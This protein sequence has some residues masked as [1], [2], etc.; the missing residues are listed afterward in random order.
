M[1]GEERLTPAELKTL[2][3]FEELDDDQLAWLAERGRVVEYPVGAVIHAEG[4]IATCFLVL[5]SGT[6]SM[7]RRVQGGTELE[8]FRTDYRG[9]YTGAFGAWIVE[10]GEP[11]NYA[12]TS[13]A[14][15]DCRFLELPA[16]DMAWAVKTWFPMA[17]HLMVGAA[18]QG[19]EASEMIERHE[20]LVAL[21]AVTAGLT[22]ELNNPVAA[23]GRAAATL[24]E[25]LNGW[26][27]EL[28]TLADGGVD[29]HQLSV[30][31][32]LVAKAV[33]G[34]SAAPHLSP[35]EASDRED[36]LGEWLE[37]HGV[38]DS[39]DVAPAL[40]AAGLDVEAVQ[41]L[42]DVLGP[43][44][45]PSG[46]ASLVYAL[47]SD[48]LVEEIGEATGRISGLLASAKQYTQ[49][50]R[51]PLQTFEV[52]EG[53]EATLTMLGHE[54]G[55]VD[56]VRDYDLSLPRIAAYPAELNQVWTNLIE[57][58]V[59]AMDGRGI[60]TVR[61]RAG[62]DADR[63]VVEFADTGPGVPSELVDRIFEPFFTTK[64]I[65]KG[66]G[67]G[68]DIVWRIVVIRHGGDVRLTST[69]GHTCFEIELPV[70]GPQ[71]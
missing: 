66:T 13:R 9:A 33:A 7:S 14:V 12:S 20:R 45:F 39:W 57:N 23:V 26:Y 31:A 28:G 51:G 40:V 38:A 52:H 3:L 6:L 24:R 35:M 5:L 47:D 64:E 53:L 11:H 8:L 61:T 67:L 21:G 4:D 46:L 25:R 16:S 62:A 41:H 27:K 37:D 54:L 48:S 56:V 50:D 30:V 42:V 29:G 69:P 10:D 44:R 59:D 1:S 43:E 65:G 2:F 17:A 68:L 18:T 70:R 36:A 63:L 34:R 55:N 22:H 19:R 58:A 32:E 60:L 15:R 49:M 71:E